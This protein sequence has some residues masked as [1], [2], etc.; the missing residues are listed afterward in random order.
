MNNIDIC[1]VSLGINS[2]KIFIGKDIH[3]SLTNYISNYKNYSKTIVISDKN[4]LEKN[5]S[6]FN[7]CFEK[8]IEFDQIILPQ[9][10]KIKSFKYLE[11]IVE[12]ILKLE[13]DRDTLLIC[14]GGGVL[15]DLVGLASSLI[16]RGLDFVQVPS[17]L[18]AQVDSSVGGKTAINSRYGKNLIGSFYQP[19][20]VISDISFSVWK[21]AKV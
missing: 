15:G 2:Y 1:K 18:L 5:P 16:L 21:H 9:G 8:Q 7:N 11:L 10:E 4:I 17:T 12:K 19:K 13:V 6:L 20:L 3:K 14:I